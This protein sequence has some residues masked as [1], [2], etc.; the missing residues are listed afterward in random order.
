[1]IKRFRKAA[2]R[3]KSKLSPQGNRTFIA[4]GHK[5]KRHDFI[6]KLFGYF[7][8]RRTHLHVLITPD[9]IQK[10]RCKNA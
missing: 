1:M 4:G 6:G 7:A 10:V 2:D 5:I 9:F 3:F 8:G